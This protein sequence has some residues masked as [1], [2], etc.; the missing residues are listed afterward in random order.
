MDQL[1]PLLA[2]IEPDR[3]IE[4]RNIFD[5][6][7]LAAAVPATVPAAAPAAA[8]AA[9]PAAT[10][11][12]PPTDRELEADRRDLARTLAQVLKPQ[13]PTPYAGE[14]DADAC[15]NFI[16][17]QREYFTVVNLNMA[18]WVQYTALNLVSDA[19]SWWRS[20]GLSIT[21][22][23][24]QFETD[25]LA[26]HTPP[27]AVAAARE[28]LESLKQGKRSVALYTHEFRRLLRRVP[29]LDTGTALHWF[30]KGLESD[31]SKEVKL[32]QCTSLEQAISTATLIHSILFPHGPTVTPTPKQSS[33]DMD[34]DNL[35]IAIN[36]LTAQVNYLSQGSNRNNA[37][38]PAKLTP[39]EKAHLIANKGCFRCRKIGHMASNCRTFPNQQQ[40][41]RPRQFNNLESYAPHQPT[42]HN[43]SGNDNSN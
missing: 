11:P 28:A 25:F 16:D 27:N 30:V 4:I 35:H 20:S 3:A 2:G 9:T 19:K 26:F 32:R 1:D 31:T 8:P 38:R 17:N 18:D 21:T 23:W 34:V 7:V 6:L 5:S 15:N 29:T 36:N 14:I 10:P 22:P 37:P 12:A 40:Q 42:A 13:R 24:P 41:Q 39:A 43:Q 33:S